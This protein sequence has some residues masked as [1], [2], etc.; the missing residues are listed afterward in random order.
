MGR[1][2]GFFFFGSGAFHTFFGSGAFHTSLHASTRFA[3][4]N[5]GKNGR[6]NRRFRY[7]GCT[8]GL[9]RSSRQPKWLPFESKMFIRHM[10]LFKS[11]YHLCCC[12]SAM[13][14][15]SGHVD[16]DHHCSTKNCSGRVHHMCF[17]TY[18]GE[19]AEELGSTTRY[20]RLCW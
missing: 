11:L 20:C 5:K 18:A 3:S 16:V 4:Q 10:Y 1:N 8:G 2:E 7:G 12:D 13:L 6:G 9:P 19:D 17:L 15:G 14:I